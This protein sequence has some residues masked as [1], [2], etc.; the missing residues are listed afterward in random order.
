[1][2]SVCHSYV[3]A[4]HPYVTRISLV[5]HPDITHM[6]SFIIRMSLVCHPYVTRM[7]PRVPHTS[8]IRMKYEYIRVTYGWHT[9]TYEWHTDDIRVHTSDIRMTY[10]WIT[11]DMR[12][13]MYEY[14]RGHMSSLFYSDVILPWTSQEHVLFILKTWLMPCIVYSLKSD[15]IVTGSISN[16]N[17]T[18]TRNNCLSLI[19]TLK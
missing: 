11:D 4:R 9:S 1:M 7:L 6:Y 3:H 17:D 14:I 5:C 10:E 2:S 12:V 15:G 19:C 16:H 13:H 8:D 18:S